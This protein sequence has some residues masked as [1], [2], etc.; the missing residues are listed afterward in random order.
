MQAPEYWRGKEGVFLVILPLVL[1]SDTYL[2]ETFHLRG[3]SDKLVYTKIHCVV[4]MNDLLLWKTTVFGYVCASSVYHT[5]AG[6]FRASFV[7][8]EVSEW[9]LV[10]WQGHRGHQKWHAGQSWSAVLDCCGTSMTLGYFLVC[11]SADAWTGWSPTVP[12]QTYP[13]VYRY[14]NLY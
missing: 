9:W 5:D 11:L 2:W 8:E 10:S 4:G 1:S 6:I 14:T 3:T 13:V 12:I 7:L